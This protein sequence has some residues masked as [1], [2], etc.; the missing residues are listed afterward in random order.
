[1]YSRLLHINE[2]TI[3]LEKIVYVSDAGHISIE[4]DHKFHSVSSGKTREVV[5]A[6]SKW[7]DYKEKLNGNS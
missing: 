2:V 5:E 6:W 4:G 7:L 3:D 1:M